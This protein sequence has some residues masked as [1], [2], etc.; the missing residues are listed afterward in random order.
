MPRYD[1][2]RLGG[3]EDWSPSRFRLGLNFSCHGRTFTTLRAR[4]A[5]LRVV[6]AV[7]THVAP[8]PRQSRIG[9]P[10][11]EAQLYKARPGDIDADDLPALY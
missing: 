10:L 3:R 4:A 7:L 11:A 2:R 1:F 5:P 9:A 8:C 6:R